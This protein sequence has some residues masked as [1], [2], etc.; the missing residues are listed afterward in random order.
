[1][2]EYQYLIASS[3]TGDVIDEFSPSS[4]NY[5]NGL[6]G[7]GSCS[8]TLSL[9]DPKATPAN[10]Q[11]LS[12]EVIVVRE[13]APVFSGPLVK[14]SPSMSNGNLAWTAA[15]AWWWMSTATAELTLNYTSQDIGEILWDHVNIAQQ[16]V[17]GGDK[18]ITR[19]SPFNATGQLL[20]VTY[21]GAARKYISEVAQE[22]VRIYP[23][24]DFMINLTWDANNRVRRDL[25]VYAPFKGTT[26]TTALNLD[27]GLTDV[28]YD[29]DGANAFNRVHEIGATTNNTVLLSSRNDT[30]TIGVSIPMVEK[31]ISRTDVTD[32]ATLALW[33][34]GD[35]ALNKWPTRVHTAS[36]RFSEN[37]PYGSITPG[38][39]VL[40]DAA[41]GRFQITANKRVTSIRVDV[42]DSGNEAATLTFN[43]PVE[44][45]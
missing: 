3:M 4:V 26:V 5:D 43:E 40:L 20:T 45:A 19:S 16:K 22:L 30:A 27:N 8:G 11:T 42:T 14:V 35:L 15:T 31:V 23:G 2:A 38:D 1:M 13:G 7:A 33:A 6:N 34:Q 17:P 41:I 29:E 36:L 18:R 25:Q 44:G 28:S 32:K 12:R 39:T 21:P 24:F 37:L 9:E 10:F